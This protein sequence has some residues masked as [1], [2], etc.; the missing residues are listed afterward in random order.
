MFRPRTVLPWRKPGN[1]EFAAGDREFQVGSIALDPVDSLRG[2]LD[3][4]HFNARSASRAGS[5]SVPQWN[6]GC[7]RFGDPDMRDWSG[8][9][10]VDACFQAPVRE[11]VFVDRSVAGWQQMVSDLEQQTRTGR[12]MDVVLLDELRDGLQQISD[13]LRHHRGVETIHIVSHAGRGAARLGNTVLD[14]QSLSRRAGSVAGWRESLSGDGEILFYGCRLGGSRAGRQLTRRI[15]RLTGAEVAVSTDLTGSAEFGGDWDLEFRT[16]TIDSRLAFSADLQSRWAYLLDVDITQAWLDAN[17]PGPWYLNQAGETYRLQTDVFAGGTAFAV[18]AQN[19]TLDLNGYTI[20]YNDAAPIDIG[21]HSFESGSGSSATSW[22]FT[23]A[24]GA[25]RYAGE[26]L[27]SE[28]FDGDHSLRFDMT[29][30]DEYV[31]SVSAITLEAN[32]TYALTGMFQRGGSGSE[33]GTGYVQLVS[34][35]TVVHEVNWSSSNSR[36]IQHREHVFTT[37]TGPETYTV[38]VGVRD[39]SSS[40][41]PFFIDDVKVHRYR[42]HGV[43][44]GPQNW[45]PGDAPDVTQFGLGHGFHLMGSGGSIVQGQ[46]SGQQSHGLSYRRGND[47]EIEGVTLRVSGV[48]SSALDVHNDTL[49]H[50]NTL[51]SDVRVTGHRDSLLGAVIDG[52][53]RVW[54]NTVI[55]GMQTGIKASDNAEIYNNTIRLRSWYTNGFAILGADSNQIYGNDIDNTGVDSHGVEFGGRGIA[56][57]GGT[58]ASPTRVHGNTVRVREVAR[59]QEYGGGVIG[60]AYGIQVEAHSYI[61]M[62]NNTVEAHAYG[63]EAHALRVGGSGGGS[64]GVEIYNNVFRAVSDGQAGSWADTLKLTDNISFG[65]IDLHDNEYRTNDGFA[66]AHKDAYVTLVRPL[67]VREPPMNMWGSAGQYPWAGGYMNRYGQ[68]YAEIRILDGS[69]DLG[70]LDDD[71]RAERFFS[72]SVESRGNHRRQWTTTIDVTDSLGHALA[73]A[74]VMLV[75]HNGTLVFSGTTDAGGQ[76]QTVVDDYHWAGDVRNAFGPYTVTA[77]WQGD[78]V[79]QEFNATSTR[80]IDLQ[81]GGDPPSADDYTL[82]YSGTTLLVDGTAGDNV[83]VWS[84]IDPLAFN[85]DGFDFDVQAG[86]TEIRFRGVAGNDSIRLSGTAGNDTA[87]LQNDR[88]TFDTGAIQ[89]KTRK[90]PDITVNGEGGANAAYLIGTPNEDTVTLASTWNS[91]VSSNLSWQS[92]GFG[93]VVAY[94]TEGYDTVTILDTAVNDQFNSTGDYALLTSGSIYLRA[95]GFE[96][97]AAHSSAG[98]WDRATFVDST[99]DDTVSGDSQVLRM[100]NAEGSREAH[101]FDYAFV[102]SEN[103]GMD[104]ASLNGTSAS[105]YVVGNVSSFTMYGNEYM[106]RVDGFVTVNVDGGGGHNR[107]YLGDSAADDQFLLSS[108]QFDWSGNGQAIT[109]SNFTTQ[110]AYTVSTGNDSV[111]I[112][113]TAGD[114]YVYSFADVMI[115][116]N[117]TSYIRGD[118]FETM[119]TSSTSGDDSATILDAA[120][121]DTVNVRSEEVEVIGGGLTRRASGFGYTRTIMQSGLVNLAGS[122]GSDTLIGNP[123]QVTFYGSGFRNF[124]TGYDH[125]LIDAAAGHDGF[126]LSDTPL[127]EVAVLQAES[128]TFSNAGSLLEMNGFENQFVTSVHGGND[129]VR[130]Y[131]SVLDDLLE[132]HMDFT[133]MSNTQSVF[134]ADGFSDVAAFAGSGGYDTVIM[135]GTPGSDLVTLNENQGLY[136]SSGLTRFFLDFDMATIYRESEN[137]T[138][139]AL[140]VWYQYELLEESF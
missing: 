60:G 41:S 54:N 50:D 111:Q 9:E 62:Y 78:Q 29:D 23:N 70:Y 128:A 57:G 38:R 63:V 67:I 127:D 14:K 22:N 83:F 68:S 97:A 47:M 76:V 115:L 59:N 51:Y 81:M 125:A 124:V 107:L 87:Y 48:E 36:A 89:V 19:V 131:D 74:S 129:T 82:T 7:S 26:F 109:A 110:V 2:L 113:D 33:H 49:I 56:P 106:H 58:E 11:L 119:T 105:D 40:G 108:S 123:D 135:T 52:G 98:G 91:L 139:S 44:V 24:P 43:F 45:A 140:D 102:T 112:V 34:G 66:L 20:T 75:D 118:G 73:N 100:S 79:Q 120:A 71:Y 93:R 8:P 69:G 126:W 96:S 116:A 121:G 55:G 122:T 133:R 130:F 53:A 1:R 16:G 42:A 15:A 117:S 6:S 13:T 101:G 21:N 134:Q 85:V 35:N 27:S 37:G 86:T 5:D 28:I 103:G 88:L 65:D 80:T 30:H 104:T 31:Q 10:F 138:V 3:N 92:T 136:E 17:S 137:D 77:S 132:S 25:Q 114:D 12:R 90:I 39:G 95:E 72:T 99:L 18:T 84:A 32:T 4:R 61:E 46:D 94:E 64:T